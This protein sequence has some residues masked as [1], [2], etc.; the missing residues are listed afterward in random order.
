M[1]PAVVELL[2]YL[3]ERKAARSCMP[4]YQDIRDCYDDTVLPFQL[5]GCGI[6]VIKGDDGDSPRSPKGHVI[7]VATLGGG[8]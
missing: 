3:L 6:Y 2:L 7:R 4:G 5:L 1:R 8:E